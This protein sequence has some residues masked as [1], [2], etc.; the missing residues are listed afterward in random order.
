VFHPASEPV[1]GGPIRHALACGKPVVASHDPQT[2]HLV[3]PAAYLAAGD[4]GR[5]LG[6]ALITVI[7]EEEVAETLAGAARARAS[8]WSGAAYSQALSGA[9]QRILASQSGKF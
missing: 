1:W 3:G 6:A 4:D 2:S 5:A 7:V 9:Y 8:T